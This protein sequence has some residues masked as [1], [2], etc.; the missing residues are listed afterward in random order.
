MAGMAS[1][2]RKRTAHDDASLYRGFVSRI[3][4]SW[5]IVDDSIDRAQLLVSELT[6][7]AVQYGRGT[8]RIA[9]EPIDRVSFRVEV[10]NTGHG[11]PTVRHPTS[12]EV[13]G[14][15]LQIVDEL[16]GAWGSMTDHGETSVWFE[17]HADASV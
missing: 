1:T 5:G 17:I 4:S 11:H 12:D 3:L 7:N 13:S 14:R 16:S 9:V 10:C 15:G 2:R 8:I 6:S